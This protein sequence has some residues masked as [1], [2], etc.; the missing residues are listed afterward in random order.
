MQNP[1]ERSAIDELVKISAIYR[2]EAGELFRE[3][4]KMVATD[5]GA[6]LELV[7]CILAGTQVPVE[8]AK[9][10]W[11]RLQGCNKIL[12]PP[13]LVSNES[14][15]VSEI[16]Q[17]LRSSGYRY[18]RQKAEVI[19]L[20]ARFVGCHCPEGIRKQLR[21]QGWE[22]FANS[23]IRN[24]KGIGKKIANH[25]LRNMGEPTSTI[26]VHLLRLFRR[27]GIL[28]SDSDHVTREDFERLQK[29]MLSVANRLGLPVGEVQYSLWLYAREDSRNRA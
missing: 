5:Q 6:W 3:K 27:L 28:E 10:S 25:W 23:L 7:Y 24:V 4:R 2:R 17:H 15:S 20:A 19:V 8:T 1:S 13:R 16:E 29:V 21:K 9:S 11:L 14:E 22:D 18:P 26:D 12:S